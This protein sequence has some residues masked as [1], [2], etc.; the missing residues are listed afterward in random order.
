MNTYGLPYDISSDMH[1]GAIGFSS[2]GQR[3]IETRNPDYQKT[4]G[5]RLDLSF[6]DIKAT[7]LAY[8][9]S[10]NLNNKLIFFTT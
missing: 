1:Y 7:N 2:N 4:I 9:R 6:L 3:T 10:N 8:C 5:Q